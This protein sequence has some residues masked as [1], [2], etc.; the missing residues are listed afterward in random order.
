MAPKKPIQ[1]TISKSKSTIELSKPTRQK[2]EITFKY[3]DTQVQEEIESVMSNVPENQKEEPILT[4]Y[5]DL[6]ST[7]W[8]LRLSSI[9]FLAKVTNEMDSEILYRA[10]I[11]K[12]SFKENNFQVMN[13]VINLMAE[14]ECSAASASLAVPL[15]T[16]KLSD[17]KVKKAAGDCLMNI[18]RWI[19]FGFVLE[20][21]TW[22]LT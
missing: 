6:S 10:L 22:K 12:P 3:S 17:I 19:S 13:Q 5:N 1:K 16:D 20:N 15:L 8:K 21:S 14:K 18:C 7:N 11:K 9:Q 4:G 2:F